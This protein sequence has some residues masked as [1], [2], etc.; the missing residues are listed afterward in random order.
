VS[1]KQVKNL[2]KINITIG[3]ITVI[4]VVYVVSHFKLYLAHVLPIDI[5]SIALGMSFAAT[6]FLWVVGITKD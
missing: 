6:M 5:I 3:V 4:E 2:I 1:P